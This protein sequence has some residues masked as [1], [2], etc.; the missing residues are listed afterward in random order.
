MVGAQRRPGGEGKATHPHVSYDLP[1]PL[2]HVSVGD[3]HGY[4]PFPAK[5][6]IT[7]PVL[8]GAI[9]IKVRAPVDLDN[10]SS[11]QAHKVQN[12]ASLGVLTTE[13]QA[14]APKLAQ[15]NP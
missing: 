15:M 1:H 9:R 5:H 2:F 4:E 14:F 8:P 3:P 11:P 10:Q 13:M 6:S 12:I 7:H